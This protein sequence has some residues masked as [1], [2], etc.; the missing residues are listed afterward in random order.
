MVLYLDKP[1]RRN[2]DLER[3]KEIHYIW[4]EML[5][6]FWRGGRWH[7]TDGLRYASNPA[8]LRCQALQMNREMLKSLVLEQVE[9]SNVDDENG[10]DHGSQWLRCGL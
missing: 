2:N 9:L 1:R 8:M 3:R 7:D 6:T 5:C 4:R 10:N